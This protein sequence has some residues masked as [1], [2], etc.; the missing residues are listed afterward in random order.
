[1]AFPIGIVCYVT[2]YPLLALSCRY[3]FKPPPWKRVGRTQ[4]TDKGCIILHNY[5]S[6]NK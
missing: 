5:T 2:L 6:L 1:M 3:Y 4:I